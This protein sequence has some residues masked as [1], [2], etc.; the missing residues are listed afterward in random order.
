[1]PRLE[2]VFILGQVTRPGA[3]DLPSLQSLTVSK[4]ISIAGGFD[5]YAKTSKVYLIR[6]N[7]KVRVIDVGAILEGD[8]RTEDPILQPG[9]TVYVPESRL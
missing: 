9:D 4:G 6:T 5:K 8:T 3:V 7:E 2:S 1:M